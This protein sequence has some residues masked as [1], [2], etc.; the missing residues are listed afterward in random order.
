MGKICKTFVEC[1]FCCLLRAPRMWKSVRIN[2]ARKNPR[3]E[4]SSQ[5]CQN[6]F[7]HTS[8]PLRR[9]LIDMCVKNTFEGLLKHW[10]KLITLSFPSGSWLQA[11][12]LSLSA[13]IS[14]SIIVMWLYYLTSTKKVYQRSIIRGTKL[15]PAVPVDERSCPAWWTKSHARGE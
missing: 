10:R 1:N 12:V 2:N 6:K 4:N 14:R 11:C 5:L 9:L 3:R 15:S 13:E 7:T 8:L